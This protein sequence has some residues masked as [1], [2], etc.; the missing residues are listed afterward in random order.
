MLQRN[1]GVPAYNLAVVVDDA[2]QGVTEVVRGDDLLASTPS[3]I[4]L[5]PPARPADPAIRARS[6]RARTGRFAPR[7]ASR[8]G[9]ARP[10]WRRA[11][12]RPAT[13]V[14]AWQQ[15]IGIDTAGQPVMAGDLLD[16]FDPDRLPSHAVAADAPD[17]L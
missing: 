9:D 10:T 11:G 6:A 2:A 3:Q 7:Q 16:R 12:S 14:R 4:M 8:R 15:S 13:C 17:E 1:D 5:L